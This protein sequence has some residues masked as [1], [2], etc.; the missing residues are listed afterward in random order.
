MVSIFDE[1][2]RSNTLPTPESLTELAGASAISQPIQIG[3]C[4]PHYW[5]CTV[6]RFEVLYPS[7]TLV[8]YV[9]TRCHRDARKLE[10]QVTLERELTSELQAMIEPTKPAL[11]YDVDGPVDAEHRAV[12]FVEIDLAESG[13]TS[14]RERVGPLPGLFPENPDP[15]PIR[16]EYSSMAE[17]VAA[18]GVKLKDVRLIS[19]RDPNT[20]LVDILEHEARM[21]NIPLRY[22]EIRDD[23]LAFAGA[24]SEFSGINNF[25]DLRDILGWH[26]DG[27]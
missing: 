10:Y 12:T 4:V 22:L 15:A 8:R 2:W 9:V 5:R 1:L 13:V 18:I 24:R 16:T 17:A 21:R 25:I 23:G 6:R 20:T 3:S 27:F 14:F 19:R 26:A 7:Q 11:L